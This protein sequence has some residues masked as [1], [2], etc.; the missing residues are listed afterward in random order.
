MKEKTEKEYMAQVASRV[1]DVLKNGDDKRAS[2]LI[3]FYKSINSLYS[4][5]IILVA[6][7]ISSI[8]SELIANFDK[9]REILHQLAEYSDERGK[10][11]IDEILYFSMGIANR[12]KNLDDILKEEKH[13]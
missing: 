12:V 2:M 4:L 5:D 13:K 7:F 3:D 6:R 1:M 11:T 9:E 8:A 10:K